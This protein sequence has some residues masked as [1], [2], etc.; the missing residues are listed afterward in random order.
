MTAAELHLKIEKF[1]EQIKGFGINNF[2]GKT[3]WQMKSEIIEYFRATNFA[4]AEEKQ[5]NWS[6]FQT[7]ADLLKEKQDTITSENEAFAINAELLIKEIE[8]TI[9]NGF[10]SNNP[11]REAIGDLKAKMDKTFDYFKQPRWPSKER[12]TAAWDHFSELREKLKQEENE[13]YTHLREAKAEQ[14]HLSHQLSL[15]IIETIEASHPDASTNFLYQAL[16]QL[17]EYLV[18]IGFAPESVEWILANKEAEPKAP[19]KMKSEG[20]KEVRRLLNENQDEL[21]RDDKQRIYAKLEMISAELNKAWDAHR[22]ELQ[23]KQEEWEERKKTNEMKRA[24][25]LVKQTD[26]LKVLTEKL[27]KRTFDKENLDKILINKKDFHSR[28]HLR[29]KNQN[30]FLA[31]ITEDLADMQEKL[32]TAWTDNFK[33]R[34]AEKVTQKETKIA[35]VKRDI[36]EVTA[37]LAEVEKDIVEITEKVAN[38]DKSTEELKLKIEEV[39]KNLE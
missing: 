31:K 8:T 34:M 14:V 21:T 35:E 1:D 12:R 32:N 26:F 6:K 16:Q 5:S 37:K 13:F 33:E 27:E 3:L 2:N 20:L 22:E 29:L 7:L 15:V 10:Y 4:D 25:W 19:L 38:I 28:Q 11:E 39:K 23:K 30:E 9:R 24:E 36:S 17:T 18:S